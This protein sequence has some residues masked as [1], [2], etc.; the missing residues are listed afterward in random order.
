MPA[1]AKNP[2]PE[3]PDPGHRERLERLRDQLTAE[4]D[5]VHGRPSAAAVAALGRELR[6]VLAELAALPVDTGPDLAT[7][8]KARRAARI[9]ALQAGQQ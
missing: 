3:V 9:A 5:G 6:A 4:I 1:R 2:R 7:E 8:L